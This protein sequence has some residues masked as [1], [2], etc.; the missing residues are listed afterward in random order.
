MRDVMSDE[1]VYQN[2]AQ[3]TSHHPLLNASQERADETSPKTF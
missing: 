1:F 2:R 3:K